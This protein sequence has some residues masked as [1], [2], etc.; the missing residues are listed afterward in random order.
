MLE[1]LTD[2]ERQLVTDHVEDDFVKDFRDW[3]AIK[4]DAPSYTLTAAALQTLSLAAGDTTVMPSIFGGHIYMN[5]FIMV[6]GP[7]TTMRKSTVLNFI[8]DLLPKNA[9]THE[10]Y[11]A[12]LD[13]VSIQA[14]NKV[15]ADQGKN[16]SPV[17]LSVDEV[18]GLFAQIR[19]KDSYLGSFDKTLMKAFDHSPVHIVRVNAKT[20]SYTGAFVNVFAASTPEPLAEVLGSRDVESGLLPRFIVFD[21]RDAMRGARIP[22]Q[23]RMAR[24]QEWEDKRDELREFVGRIAAAR[25]GGIPS[26]TDA[27]GNPL[28]PVKV[29]PIE[30]D[31]F[32]RLDQI[33]ALFYHSAGTDSTALG[34]IKGRAFWHVA[35]VSGLYALARDGVRAK[36]TMMDILR[37]AW[38]IETTSADLLRM[39]DEVGTNETERLINEVMGIIAETKGGRV[40]QSV[41]TRRLKLD[42]RGSRDLIGT[43]MLRELVNVAADEK[44]DFWWI[45][46]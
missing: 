1:I 36:I 40:R 42:A 3:A 12:I 41:M 38:L 9:Q 28:F 37:A 6:V 20:D 32:E 27:E 31:A 4:T 22:L 33:E 17:L 19:K 26:G 30:P 18:A 46:V 8:R 11:I 34:A 44:G 15:M 16:M 23:D 7:S 5:L 14:F 39:A 21:A 35:K 10:P 2:R 13:D 29:L 43:L 45:R 24:H 25:A